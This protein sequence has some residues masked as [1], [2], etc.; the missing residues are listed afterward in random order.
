MSWQQWYTLKQSKLKKCPTLPSTWPNTNNLKNTHPSSAR[1]ER[2]QP[3][4]RRRD[5]N[6]ILYQRVPMRRRS[7]DSRS[8]CI[9]GNIPPLRLNKSTL[10]WKKQ[11]ERGK[12]GLSVSQ[13]HKPTTPAPTA[14]NNKCNSP[15]QMK[16]LV[17]WRGNLK[18]T[19]T[20]L[21]MFSCVFVVSLHV[22]WIVASQESKGA[23]SRYRNHD[24]LES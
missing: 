10:L 3:E 23:V 14:L 20:C 17:S 7:S 12:N 21:C 22:R 4:Q 2:P 1:T 9:A 19:Q 5:W 6:P 16:F 13:T 11:R 8:V 15:R 24:F 18:L